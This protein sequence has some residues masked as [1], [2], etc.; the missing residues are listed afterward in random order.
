M[1]TIRDGRGV[2]TVH[3]LSTPPTGGVGPIERSQASAARMADFAAERARA[4][5]KREPRVPIVAT[6]AE[7]LTASRRGTARSIEVRQEKGTIMANPARAATGGA[8]HES[9]KLPR[10][11]DER[12]RAVLE[13]VRTSS[14]HAEAGAK[15]GVGGQR[16]AQFVSDLRRAGQLPADVEK[17]LRARSGH[18]AAGEAS[19]H[20][21]PGPEAGGPAT[22]ALA[23]EH[24]ERNGSAVG[25][26][27]PDAVTNGTANISPPD[28][29]SI[30]GESQQVLVELLAAATRAAETRARIVAELAAIDRDLQATLDRAAAELRGLS[31]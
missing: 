19:D 11:R 23:A 22:A 2:L 17:L 24:P 26:T 7:R 9:V 4:A 10:D 31:A 21:P 13:A 12:T 16:I 3:D 29:T 30:E 6:P 14:S 20:E 15:L 1:P 25:S 28:L 8:A 5:V 18:R 27:P